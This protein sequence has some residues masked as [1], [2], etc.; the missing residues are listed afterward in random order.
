M[1]GI[2]AGVL[3][4]FIGSFLNVLIDRLPRGKDVLVSR[5]VCD[6]CGKTLRWYELIPLLSFAL[7]GGRCR[8]C[9]KRLS[10]QY[11]GVELLTAAVYAW[12][13]T[14]VPE[15]PLL[16]PLLV[17]FSSFIVI[18][19]ADL[20][21]QIIPDSMVVAALV[22]AVW[23]GWV[24]DGLAGMP[25]RLGAGVGALGFFLLLWL[26]TRG[27]GMGFG[28]VKLAFALGVLLSLPRIIFALYISFISGAVVGVLLLGLHNKT[29]KS[30]IPFG[31][32]LILGT[33]WVLVSPGMFDRFWSWL[34]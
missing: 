13:G 27:R 12:A 2:V 32:F 25:L 23:L 5:S 20:K 15:L 11:P 26:I 24:T 1:I 18:T 31:P 30:R 34:F 3:G 16:L 22:G 8:R 21:F 9:R 4:A 19:I 14:A 33:V 28:D 7:Q 17:V 29:L 10:W 6:Y